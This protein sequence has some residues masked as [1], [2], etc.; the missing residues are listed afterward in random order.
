MIE[1]SLGDTDRAALESE[2]PQT[3]AKIDQK[4]PLTVNDIKKMSKIGLSDQIII[5]QI[6]ATGS[7]FYLSTADI[8]DL[9]SAGVSQGVI[10]YMIKTGNQ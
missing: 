2:S 10:D 6:E 8:I 9:K 3:L 4:E 7:V 1:I 5:S